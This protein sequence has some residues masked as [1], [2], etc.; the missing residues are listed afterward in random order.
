MG[1]VQQ[2]GLGCWGR[3]AIAMV[4]GVIRKQVTAEKGLELRELHTHVWGR[5]FQAN[6]IPGAK[7]LTW[8]RTWDVSGTQRPLNLQR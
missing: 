4:T 5:I 6:G 8:K 1:R 3:K 2:G 7:A